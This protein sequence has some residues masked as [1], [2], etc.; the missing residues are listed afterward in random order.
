MEELAP[1]LPHEGL[2]GVDEALG[3]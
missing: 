1:H 2:E 3:P